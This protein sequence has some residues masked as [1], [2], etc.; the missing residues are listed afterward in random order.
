MRREPPTNPT[1]APRALPAS[2]PKARPTHA[3][4][5]H[6]CEPDVSPAQAIHE[7][8][9]S[10]SETTRVPRQPRASFTRAPHKLLPSPTRV[11]HEPRASPTRAQRCLPKDAGGS[12]LIERPVKL[13]LG[14]FDSPRRSEARL[15]CI[16]FNRIVLDWTYMERSVLDL[17]LVGIAQVCVFH[18]MSS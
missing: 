14:G 8:H 3:Y 15:G 10:P 2:H 7:H 13:V 18:F 4:R 11:L 6:W 1:R 9:A 5:E 17:D 16:D 12:L